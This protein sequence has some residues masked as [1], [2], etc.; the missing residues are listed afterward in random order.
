MPTCILREYS[1]IER[2]EISHNHQIKDDDNKRKILTFLQSISGSA[3]NDDDSEIMN[4]FVVLLK[5]GK[6]LAGLRELSLFH[7]LSDIPGD[8]I[9][10]SD[11]E[12]LQ[13]S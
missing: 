2:Q 11:Q 8:F 9:R 10:S 4:L 5:S 12:I 13:G 1:Y 6:V 3:S 7:S